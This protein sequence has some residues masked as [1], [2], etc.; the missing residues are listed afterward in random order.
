MHQKYVLDN[1][2]PQQRIDA[3]VD[4]CMQNDCHDSRQYL[5]LKDPVC[6][7][8]LELT[9]GAESSCNHHDLGLKLAAGNSIGMNWA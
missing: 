5:L 7:F 9:S 1:N 6:K 4:A 2:I 3:S 8:L